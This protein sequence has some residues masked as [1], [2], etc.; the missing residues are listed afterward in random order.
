MMP[1]RTSNLSDPSISST[2]ES[3]LGTNLRPLLPAPHSRAIEAHAEHRTAPLVRRGAP[4]SLACESC[5]QRKVR[6][7]HPAAI[8]YRAIQTRPEAEA[9][10]IVR[11]IRAGTDAETMAHQLSTAD[12][13]LQ[14]Q[15]EPETRYRY[16][17]LYSRLMPS[18]LQT[19]TN[20]FIH[21]LIYEWNEKDEAGKVSVPPL[22]ESEQK[23]KAQYLRPVHAASIVDPRMDEIVPSKWTSVNADDNLMRT[24][25][26]AYF[27]YEY[28][29]FTFFHKDYF[30]D[31]MLAGSSNFCSPLLVNA[32]LAV[33]CLKLHGSSPL[34]L[35]QDELQKSLA[36]YRAYFETI[37]RIHYLRH[38]FEYGN[39]ML[40]HFLT[41]LAFLALLKLD[42]LL[43][44]DPSEPEVPSMDV[45][46]SDLR[47]AKATLLIAQK[48]LS[49]QGRGCY[50]PKRVLQKV[51]SRLTPSDSNVLQSVITIQKEGPEAAEEH[52]MPAM[53]YPV[54]PGKL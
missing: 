42:T 30:L 16:Q 51:L 1:T 2:H 54:D 49:D 20:P 21:S 33:G 14:V 10:E 3:N 37:L 7:S 24:L 38:S 23:Y 17:F 40:T 41:M 12:L 52:K 31:D 43:S 22:S 44:P 27:I 35:D 5:R 11:R 13:L 48:G 50:L 47:A 25:I 9:H 53:M 6:V 45:G 26:R 46:D 32:I 29:W 18:Y 19:P 36:K 34:L 4:T 15:L 8:V 28:D 39:M